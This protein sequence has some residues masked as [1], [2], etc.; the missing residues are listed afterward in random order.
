M[1]DIDIAQSATLRPIH[2]IARELGLTDEQWEPHGRYKAKITGIPQTKQQGRL[3]L[4]T[5]ISPTKYG[6]GKTTVSVGLADGLRRLEK[7]AVLCLREPSLGPVFGVKGGAAGGGYAQVVPM[8]ELNL[9]FTGD[10]H[11]VTAANNLLSAAIDNHLQHG[12]ALDIDERRVTWKRCMDI[13]DRALREI[14]TGL[15]GKAGGVPREE[16]FTIT[17]ASEVMAI[18]CM[19]ADAAD[20]KERLGRIV[21]GYTRKG[22]PVTCAALKVQG[23]MAVLLRDALRP[24]LVQT[25]EHT[26]TLIH[27][28]P[29]ANIAHGCNSLIA[30][31]AAL[32]LGDVVVTEAGFGAD[33][34]AEKFIDIKCRAGGLSPSACVIVATARA[35]KHHGGADNLFAHIENVTER[36]GLPAVV[37]INRFAADTEEDIA[38]VE[39]ACRAAQTPCAVYEGFAR[40]GAGAEALAGK[41]LSLLEPGPRQLKA[42]Y[43]LDMP[44]ADKL[45]AIAQNV[46]GADGAD[47]APA[48]KKQAIKLEAMGYGNLPVCVA[49]TQYSLSDD[50]KKLGRP[51]GFRVTIDEL[52]VSAGAGFVVAVAGGMMTMPGLT[53]TPAYEKIDIDADGRIL[54]LF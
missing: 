23:A 25:L 54:G 24:N 1:T 53:A 15:G 16:G 49:K 34:G 29:F 3:V 37:A 50:A 41:L 32:A 46:Y 10:L 11:A 44:L 31:R 33:L 43:S 39:A 26:P 30:T 40:G 21:I 22:E 51:K 4:V 5:A 19:S 20:C 9:H 52:R 8:E 38:A 12:N 28:G 36:Y 27:G 45:N 2:E 14:V 35:F 17:A 47:L 48:A 42:V 6:E 18:L 7:K 13:N